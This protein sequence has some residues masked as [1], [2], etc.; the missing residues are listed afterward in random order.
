ML[1]NDSKDPIDLRDRAMMELMYSSGLRLSELQGLNLN[2]I[3]TRVREVRSD[4]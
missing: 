1:S 2:S 4:W 3:N